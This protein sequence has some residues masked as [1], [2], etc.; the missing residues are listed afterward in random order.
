MKAKKE[1]G[2]LKVKRTQT[3]KFKINSYKYYFLLFH[4]PIN[5]IHVLQIKKRNERI[6]LNPSMGKVVKLFIIVAISFIGVVHRVGVVVN[7]TCLISMN[8]II[9]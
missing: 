2:K 7:K 5:N 4:K 6:K 8:I 9:V 3:H 1:N